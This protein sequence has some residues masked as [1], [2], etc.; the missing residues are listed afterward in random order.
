MDAK[1]TLRRSQIETSLEELISN[2]RAADFQRVAV[3]LAQERCPDLI[4]S[5]L[6]HDGGEDAFTAYTVGGR[7]LAV[8]CSL[9]ATLAKIKSDLEVIRTRKP[10]ISELWFFT[11]KPVR[12]RTSDAWRKTLAEDHKVALTLITREEIVSRLM[13]PR[14]RY[15]LVQ[16]LGIA[17]DIDDVL[18]KLEARLRNHASERLRVW[19]EL[20]ARQGVVPMERQFKT[21]LSG[22]SFTT[23]YDTHEV[24]VRIASGGLVAV[25]GEAGL[26]KTVILATL[27]DQLA[28]LKAA[29]LPILISAPAWA[30]S[31]QTLVLFV[32]ELM[33]GN[34]TLAA[35]FLELCQTGAV[36]I[37]LNGWNEIA[38]DQLAAAQ[39]QL[40]DFR[41]SAPACLVVVTA[42]ARSS[43]DALGSALTLEL[44]PLSRVARRQMIDQF[45][46]SHAHRVEAQLDDNEHA[47]HLSRLPL[48]LHAMIEVLV[49]GDALPNTR[50]GILE[51]ALTAIERVPDHREALL[52]PT[53]SV[54]WRD[55]LKKLGFELSRSGTTE[56]DQSAALNLLSERTGSAEISHRLVEVLVDHHVLEQDERASIRFQHQY[57]QDWYCAQSLLEASGLVAD[58]TLASLLDARTLHDA[59]DLAVSALGSHPNPEMEWIERTRR[60]FRLACRVDPSLAADWVPTLS[61]IIDGALKRELIER[62][63]Q[64]AGQGD[65]AKRSALLAM[66]AT[67]LADFADIFWPLLESAEGS[68]RHYIQDL[69]DLFPVEVLGTGWRVRVATWSASRRAEFG[70]FAATDAKESDSLSITRE[71]ALRD[72]D[73]RVRAKCFA[74]LHSYDPGGA[75]ALLPDVAI[76]SAEVILECDPMRNLPPSFIEPL[77]PALE[78]IVR[79]ETSN[80]LAPRA[81]AYLA[82][83]APARAA[84]IYRERLN[85]GIHDWSAERQAI[86]FVA[87]QD[88]LWTARFT[89]AGIERGRYSSTWDGARLECVPEVERIAALRRVLASPPGDVGTLDRKL[90]P[91]LAG[92]TEQMARDW[93]EATIVALKAHSDPLAS[94]LDAQRRRPWDL[95]RAASALPFGRL[96]RLAEAWAQAFTGAEERSFYC[97]MLSDSA[98]QDSESIPEPGSPEGLHLRQLVEQSAHVILSDPDANGQRAARVVHLVT[99]LGY[100][101]LRPLVWTLIE[102]ESRRVRAFFAD[103]PPG[104]KRQTPQGQV[105]HSH[106]REYLE[107][108]LSV[109]QDGTV[110]ALIRLMDD[111][112]FERGAARAIMARTCIEPAGGIDRL[113]SSVDWGAVA[114]MHLKPSARTL[115]VEARQA[116]AAFE[117]HLAEWASGSRKPIG[118]YEPGGPA[119]AEFNV[120]LA[121]VTGRLSPTAFDMLRVDHRMAWQASLYFE[122]LLLRG[123]IVPARVADQYLQASLDDRGRSSS[124]DQWQLP[125]ELVIALMFSDSPELAKNRLEDFTERADGAWQLREIVQPL[126]ASPLP[127]KVDLLLQ[128][129]RRLR[130][131]DI[132]YWSR[133]FELLSHSDQLTVASRLLQDAD[134]F[135]NSEWS[136]GRFEIA[137]LFGSMA[138]IAEN[139]PGLRAEIERAIRTSESNHHRL[140]AIRLL[141]SIADDAVATRMIGLAECEPSMRALLDEFFRNARWEPREGHFLWPDHNTPRALPATRAALLRLAYH[142]SADTRDWARNQLHLL[143][144]AIEETPFVNEPRHPDLSSQL[145]WPPFISTTRAT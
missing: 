1:Q 144:V 136:S 90:A 86:E 38:S 98:G 137:R 53:V 30:R 25:V 43:T 40:A 93:M 75:C 92:A 130:R 54:Y 57:F 80:P 65:A 123:I 11:P 13:E 29:P 107:M 56:I 46:Q 71:F 68:I 5:E 140:F 72:P 145:D 82:E 58:E 119:I 105:F 21:Q 104:G 110:D 27:A 31:D 100:S 44:T 47:E 96:L 15:L 118:T 52:A 126:A 91:L 95:Q 102:T 113:R 74:Q 39:S 41:R 61:Q 94:T 139:D 37:L 33:T 63:R 48:F 16:H 36:A 49:R 55:S 78:K 2:N 115:S 77:L 50:Y 4:A 120:L 135:E 134:Y 6:S 26:G 42:R 17:A 32:T 133:A 103:A 79:E 132:Y 125:R 83:F 97:Q 51:S 69:R 106:D 20:Y 87:A 18:S 59:W 114:E 89:L 128:A 84:D 24:A 70:R 143:N 81:L 108:L 101:E 35:Q 117:R 3:R 22:D 64:W 76:Q 34:T 141:A 19:R 138:H 129:L 23:Q 8:A 60:I 73:P 99:Q 116:V 9:T 85:Q 111:P 124:Q 122:Q 14:F 127:F 112:A 121:L 88:P 67:R 12:S 109:T 62:L 45:A 142:S 10:H 7:Q 28:S 66:L 131:D